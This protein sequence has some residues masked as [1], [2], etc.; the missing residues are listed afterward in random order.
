M[1]FLAGWMVSCAGIKKPVNSDEAVAQGSGAP[2]VSE[3]KKK[4]FEYLFIE[5]Y[6]NGG[7][8]PESSFTFRLS[9]IDPN[10]QPQCTSWPT[11]ISS[12]TI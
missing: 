11:F 2:A 4:E 6:K 5:A 10:S 1:L 7:E 12:T 3:E 8:S 9:E